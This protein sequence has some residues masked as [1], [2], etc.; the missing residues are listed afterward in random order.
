MTNNLK[1]IRKYF[2]LTEAQV[3]THIG[4]SSCMWLQ[5]MEDCGNFFFKY[6]NKLSKLY[7]LPIEAFT[8][9]DKDKL[10]EMLSEVS[11]IDVKRKLLEKAVE[12]LGFRFDEIDNVGEGAWDGVLYY[13][14]D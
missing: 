10:D 12:D 5:D 9:P 3:A 7:G 2:G 14:G 11:A 8:E 4:I 1:Y 13:V 6:E